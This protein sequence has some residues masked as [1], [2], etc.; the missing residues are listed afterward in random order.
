MARSP[1]KFFF[2]KKKT[3]QEVIC[4]SDYASVS[5]DEVTEMGRD[6]ITATIAFVSASVV[7]GSR[8][9]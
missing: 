7:T 5:H 8:W 4:E 3:I 6:S 2:F 9:R 1:Q